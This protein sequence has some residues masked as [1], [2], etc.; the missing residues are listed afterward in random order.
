[1]RLTRYSPARSAA[2]A[3]QRTAEGARGQR[4]AAEEL[5]EQR[6]AALFAAQAEREAAAEVS[7]NACT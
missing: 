5:L 4:R 7:R 2:C 3:S 6:E 1:M